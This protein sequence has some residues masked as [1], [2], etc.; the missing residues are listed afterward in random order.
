MKVKKYELPCANLT[1]RSLD[2]KLPTEG[3]DTPQE[4]QVIGYGKEIK[5][6]YTKVV[7]LI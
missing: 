2:F 6:G 3:V 4:R 7:N 1:V 5:R